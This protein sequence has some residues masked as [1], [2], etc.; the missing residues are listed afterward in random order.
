M[1]CNKFRTPDRKQWEAVLLL[2]GGDPADD[3]VDSASKKYPK[4]A[5][6]MRQYGDVAYDVVPGGDVFICGD[7]NVDLCGFGECEYA[8]EYLCDWPVGKGKTCD[9]PICRNH[10]C[11]QRKGIHFCPVHQRSSSATD[12]SQM[13]DN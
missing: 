9:L 5:S 13:A 11:E 3:D 1:T 12:T 6:W 10:A 8:A 4:F 7:I 2:I